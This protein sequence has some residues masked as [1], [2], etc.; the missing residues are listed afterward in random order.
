MSLVSV[1][2]SW[3]KQKKHLGSNLFFFFCLCT[4]ELFYCWSQCSVAPWLSPSFDTHLTASGASL[5]VSAVILRERK[6]ENVVHCTCWLQPLL[7]PRAREQDR[8]V[9]SFR[10]LHWTFYVNSKAVVRK[11]CGSFP[12]HLYNCK[13]K[14]QQ[15]KPTLTSELNK[16]NTWITNTDTHKHILY[17]SL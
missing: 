17:K 8:L 6:W 5:Y 10:Q 3:V 1:C 15:R 9:P 4:Q 13:Y 16:V 12:R 7:S 2:V 11:D 14:I